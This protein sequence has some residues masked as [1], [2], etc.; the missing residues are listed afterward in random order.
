MAYLADTNVASRRVLLSDPLYSVV[1]NALDTL[2]L[3][4]E[5]VYVTA[6]NFVEFQA[7]ATRPIEAN[8]LGLTPAQANERAM[9]IEIL[10]PMLPEVPEIYAH[11]R[12][13]METIE[14]RGRQVYDARLVAVIVPTTLPIFSP[15]TPATSIAFLTS[16]LLSQTAFD[17]YPLS[18]GYYSQ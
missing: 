4:G 13:L 17:A 1:K 16:V 9:D 15:S 14:V 11:W 3:Q 12:F 18:T 7:L 5:T 8:G 10:F 6:Q 2:L